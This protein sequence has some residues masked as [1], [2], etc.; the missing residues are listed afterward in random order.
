MSISDPHRM[1]VMA[2]TA[3]DPQSVLAAIE[4]SDR[5]LVQDRKSVV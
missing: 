1:G 4:G 3:H 5:F 2:M